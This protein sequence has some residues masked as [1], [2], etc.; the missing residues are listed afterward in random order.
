VV[1]GIV[2]VIK[3]Q[4]PAKVIAG[5]LEKVDEVNAKLPPG[6]KILPVYQRTDLTN[7]TVR[8]VSENLLLGAGL[9]MAIMLTF[10]R[11]WRTALIVATVIPLSLLAAFI[12]LDARGIS[13]NLIS[14]GAVDFGII[15]DSAVVVVEALMVKLALGPAAGSQANYGWRFQ[16]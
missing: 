14:L 1:E 16:T 12:M 15:V 4:D 13:A 10:L 3:G 11:S 8:T 6:V 5:L 2:Q 9:V 7:N